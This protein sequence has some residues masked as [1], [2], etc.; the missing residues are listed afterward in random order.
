MQ[1]AAKWWGVAV[2][3]GAL[4]TG[5]AAGRPLGTSTPYAFGFYASRLSLW[6]CSLHTLLNA[7]LSLAVNALTVCSGGLLSARAARGLAVL[8]IAVQAKSLCHATSL[9]RMAQA[10]GEV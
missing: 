6:C 8:S 3:V 2:G 5:P 7:D 9:R 10:F 4:I 1:L